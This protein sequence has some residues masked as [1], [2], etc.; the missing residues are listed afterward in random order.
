LYLRFSNDHGDKFLPHQRSYFE[1][2]VQ[3]GLTPS[4]EASRPDNRTRRANGSLNTSNVSQY[5]V[6]CG[7]LLSILE[8]FSYVWSDQAS[9]EDVYAVLDNNKVMVTA[10]LAC[11]LHRL[12]RVEDSCGP[13]L[14]KLLNIIW[15]R[16]LPNRS[17]GSHYTAVEYEMSIRWKR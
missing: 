15:K 5:V 8:T 14:F 16:T 11:P 10:H 6:E 2:T 4:Q 17:H 1:K 12:C 13:M 7:F 3:P 9:V